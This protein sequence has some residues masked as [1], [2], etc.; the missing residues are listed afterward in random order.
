MCDFSTCDIFFCAW[1]SFLAGSTQHQQNYWILDLLP[2]WG[3][4]FKSGDVRASSLEIF[5]G[6]GPWGSSKTASWALV[7]TWWSTGQ[8]LEGTQPF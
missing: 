5:M 3:K 1:L 8:F 7:P 2:S 4:I 6:E